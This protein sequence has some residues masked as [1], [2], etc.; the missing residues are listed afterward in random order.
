MAAG[1]SAPTGGWGKEGSWGEDSWGKD[2]WAKPE[3]T[4]SSPTWSKPEEKTTTLYL[5]PYRPTHE[6]LY[7]DSP[8]F[9]S[10]CRQC[11]GEALA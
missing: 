7:Y 2:A 9:G 4:Y 11:E 3:K 8:G 5:Q 10:E 1:W 6:A